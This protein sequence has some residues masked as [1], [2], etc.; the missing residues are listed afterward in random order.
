M[1]THKRSN[2]VSYSAGGAQTP[3]LVN[4]GNALTFCLMVVTAFSASALVNVIGVRF[5]LALGTMGYAPY[6][7][8]LYVN[9]RYGTDWFV[10][11]GAALCGL[12]AGTFWATEAAVAL[13]YP[14]PERQ[15]KFL[16]FWLVR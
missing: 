2:T 14:E 13:S 3:Y 16:G 10:L 1:L 5:T 9:N 11:L 6:A 4:T 12:A 15:G 7:A 8:A